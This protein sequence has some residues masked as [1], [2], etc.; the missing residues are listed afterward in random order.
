MSR[1]VSSQ[2]KTV[3]QDTNYGA[4][5]KV[6]S[7]WIC[8]GMDIPKKAVQTITKYSIQ[9]EDVY[10]SVDVP[11]ENYDLM[12]AY[13]LRLGVGDTE[14]RAI[15][16]LQTLF[17]DEHSVEERLRKLED[18]YGICETKEFKEEVAKMCTFSQAIKEREM[19][20]GLEKGIEEGRE[21]G[22]E[23]GREVGRKEGEY[24]AL[25]NLVKDGILSIEIA[26]LR[27][28][29]APEEFM[30]KIRELGLEG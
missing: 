4:L 27:V 6:Y 30:D 18:I 1:M 16:M 14:K 22:I 3:S 26:A 9:K 20:R 17:M 8:M 19:A 5:Q 7:I 21:V 29:L 10:G 25:Y 15:G 11:E 28:N 24:I 2:L 13:I 12:C 23:E